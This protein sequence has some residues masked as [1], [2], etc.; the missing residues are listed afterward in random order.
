MFANAIVASGSVE[1]IKVGKRN[2]DARV[3]NQ[4]FA[5]LALS[6]QTCRPVVQF[7]VSQLLQEPIGSRRS[8]RLASEPLEVEGIATTVSGAVELLRTDGSILATVRLSAPVPA[9]CSDCAREYIAPLPLAFSEEFWPEYDHVSHAPVEMPEGREGFRIIQGQLDLSEAARQY[10]EMA[11]P[12]RPFCGS[13]CRGMPDASRQGSR[14]EPDRR[15][16][17]LERLRCELD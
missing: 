17:A 14:R 7:N 9:V 2:T 8:F 4:S 1:R 12:M 3:R 5:A 11:R 13:E 6:L 15:W 10:V 16:G